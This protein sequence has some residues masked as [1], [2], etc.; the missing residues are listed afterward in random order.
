[1]DTPPGDSYT[2][3]V[4]RETLRLY[5]PGWLIT[6]RAKADDRIGPYAVPAGA[7]IFIPV[8]LLHRHPDFWSA[9]EV[10]DPDRFAGG[11]EPRDRYAYLPFSEG[12]RAC[13][14]DGFALLE[15]EIHVRTVASALRLDWIPGQPVEP[16]PQ[17]N[18]RTRHGLS[19]RPVLR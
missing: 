6:K 2:T 1:V 7:Q 8:Y 19:F 16:E 3:R 18:L 17:I 14:G 13:I 10:F 15:M 12:P 9:P 5:P 4:I 11:R